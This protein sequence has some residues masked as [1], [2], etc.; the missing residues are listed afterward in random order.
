M[1]TLENA[2]KAPHYSNLPELKSLDD[3]H[4]IP[5]T[6][7]TEIRSA[8]EDARVISGTP[9]Y[10]FFSGGT[11]GKSF[12]YEASKTELDFIRSFFTEV[13]SGLPKLRGIRISD[14]NQPKERYVPVP[15]HFHHLGVY[16]PGVFSH[17]LDLFCR[18]FTDLGIATNCSVFAAGQRV[19]R[20]FALWL[21]AHAP[22]NLPINLDFVFTHGF[23]LTGF[24]RSLLQ[25]V[26]G[27][28]TIDRYGL[29]EVFGG[30]TECLNCGWYHFD[31]QVYAEAIDLQTRRPVE[32]GLALI[33]LTPLFPFQQRQPL[34]RYCTEDLAEVTFS[35]SCRPGELSIKPHGRFAHSLV[36][37]SGKV[38]LTEGE[39]LEILDSNETIEREKVLLDCIDAN[40]SWPI[41]RPKIEFKID[42]NEGKC[43]V[44]FMVQGE[45]QRV[46]FVNYLVPQMRS[47]MDR[48]IS[49]ASREQA[50][51]VVAN[52]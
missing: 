31:P 42:S 23:Y 6:S 1:A 38:I 24:A 37:D 12:S 20:T 9:N 21:K 44:V 49:D 45:Q 3:W 39:L 2:R 16:N 35:Q 27:C 34:L 14:G 13:A 7:K 22:D 8:G 29:S 4:L 47:M 36:A 26:F 43:E 33:V 28:P 18:K 15:I 11:T 52:V 19:S 32:E 5:L 41:G 30:A 40:Q 17:A 51:F 25:E 10:Q 48:Y 46:N 50:T